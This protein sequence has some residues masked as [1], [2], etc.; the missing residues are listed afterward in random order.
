MI[1]GQTLRV[2]PE[3]K[4][5]PTFPDHARPLTSPL[6]DPKIV[7]LFSQLELCR[8]P[9]W[10]FPAACPSL[11]RLRGI[12]KFRKNLRVRA[13]R[14]THL[15][16]FSTQAKLA[17]SLIKPCSFGWYFSSQCREDKFVKRA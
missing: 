13:P 1:S 15:V 2:C 11:G 6:M 16:R 17:Q 9:A 5:L 14:V 8:Q 4:P 10:L 7:D 3:G 12:S